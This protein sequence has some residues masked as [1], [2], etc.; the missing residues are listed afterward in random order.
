MDRR[1]GG[2]IRGTVEHGAE[3]DSEGE[4]IHQDTA[5]PTMQDASEPDEDD[6]AAAAA[7]TLTH[8]LTAEAI[9]DPSQRLP[10]NPS[11]TCAMPIFRPLLQG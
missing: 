5:Y 10:Q 3:G 8:N 9:L 1:S 7:A 6:A 2:A 11:D 4:D